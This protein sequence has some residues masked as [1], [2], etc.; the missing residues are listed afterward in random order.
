MSDLYKIVTNSFMFLVGGDKDTAKIMLS[1]DD[2][3]LV[4]ILDLEFDRRS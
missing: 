2:L 3:S 1:D 4:V